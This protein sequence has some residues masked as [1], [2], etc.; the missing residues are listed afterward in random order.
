MRELYG[1][2]T[3]AALAATLQ[4]LADEMA[5]SPAQIKA[6]VL[7][8]AFIAQRQ[9]RQVQPGDLLRAL[10]REMSKEGRGVDGQVRNH[11]EQDS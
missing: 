9:G 4:K 8:S 5:I 1:D 3:R 2:Q 6:T 11:L 10:Q 7:A